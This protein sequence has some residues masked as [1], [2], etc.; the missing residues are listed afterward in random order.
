MMLRT[1]STEIPAGDRW[2]IHFVNARNPDDRGFYEHEAGVDL[3]ADGELTWDADEFEVLLTQ[4]SLGG[5]IPGFPDAIQRRYSPPSIIVAQDVDRVDF[6]KRLSKC[7]I[8]FRRSE[9]ETAGAVTAIVPGRPDLRFDDLLG[10]D[11]DNMSAEH[12]WF[13]RPDGDLDRTLGLS[14]YVPRSPFSSIGVVVD[15]EEQA[16]VISAI[17]TNKYLRLR[18]HEPAFRHVRS[19]LRCIFLLRESAFYEDDLPAC[20][21]PNL[22]RFGIRAAVAPSAEDVRHKVMVDLA[23]ADAR[24]AALK[25]LRYPDEGSWPDHEYRTMFI[26]F[27]LGS[28]PLCR[29]L[30]FT[31]TV[32][33]VDDG[34]AANRYRFD[35]GID[36]CSSPDDQYAMFEDARQALESHLGLGFFVRTYA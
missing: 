8:V 34:V 23:I 26:D 25:Y 30:E 20:T 5:L 6:Q 11:S 14:L 36:G 24:R 13:C 15:D 27:E 18:Q 22:G 9:F 31:N 4:L 19:Q 10:W 7:G 21:I 33:S 35:I 3:P 12:I 29:F 32:K 17:L 2:M 16:C 1:I 28:D